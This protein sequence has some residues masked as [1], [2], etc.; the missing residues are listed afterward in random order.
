VKIKIERPNEASAPQIFAQYLTT[1]L[2]LAE[3][4]VTAAGERRRP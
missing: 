3:A 1:D 2:P 4:E